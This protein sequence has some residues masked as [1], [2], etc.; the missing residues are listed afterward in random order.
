VGEEVLDQIVAVP[1]ADAEE[2]GGAFSLHGLLEASPAHEQPVIGAD[3]VHRAYQP[4]EDLL[5]NRR[6]GGFHLHAYPGIAK[7]EGAGG[8]K[9]IDSLVGTGR[10]LVDSVALRLQDRLHEGREAV[11]FELG[12]DQA[13]DLVHRRLLDVHQRGGLIVCDHVAG[14]VAKGRLGVGGNLPIVRGHLLD[15]FL[16]IVALSPADGEEGSERIEDVLIETVARDEVDEFLRGLDSLREGAGSGRRTV[17]FGAGERMIRSYLI[18][19]A[20]RIEKGGLRLVFKNLTSSA[21]RAELL[22]KR[23]DFGILRKDR[24]PTGLMSIAMKPIP[25]CLLLP[26]EVAAAHRKW[27]W[28]D[29]S[30]VPL[31]LLEGDE[32]FSDFLK[33]RCRE[34]SV[35]LDVAAEFSSWTQLLDGMQEF[36]VGGF[37]PKDLESRFP[38]GFVSVALPKLSEYADQFVIAWSSSEVEKRPELGRLVKSLR[39]K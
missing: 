16:G 8:G 34:A 6:I 9:Q 1:E 4:V 15:P 19:W 39:G 38:P 26:L 3:V 14:P 2:L 37:I 12:K 10:R 22:A 27:T 21:T 20:S 18:P 7:A 36:Q 33:E 17:V 31:L 5:F 25:I 30:K 23:V 29:V 13:G 32:R 28:K 24:C 11:A 35:E